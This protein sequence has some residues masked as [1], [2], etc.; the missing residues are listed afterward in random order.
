[1]GLKRSGPNCESEKK[2]SV[3]D[4]VSRVGK[5]GGANSADDVVGA[6]ASRL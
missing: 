4:G 3:A 6:L 1:M 5:S 2:G